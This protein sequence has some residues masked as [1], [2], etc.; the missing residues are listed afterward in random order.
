[1]DRITEIYRT[2]WIL[3]DIAEKNPT[4]ENIAAA[5]E[6]LRRLQFAEKMLPEL[7]F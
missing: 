6:A 2:W 7:C 4:P 5:A 1:M 3:N